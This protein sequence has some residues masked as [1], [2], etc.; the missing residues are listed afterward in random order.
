MHTVHSWNQTL[1]H[2]LLMQGEITIGTTVFNAQQ[3]GCGSRERT[4]L[5]K[6]RVATAFWKESR[7]I[8]FSVERR[9]QLTSTSHN[10]NQPW[11]CSLKVPLNITK[12]GADNNSQQLNKWPVGG[13]SHHK[14]DLKNQ[15]Q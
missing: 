5:H 14:K 7:V 10:I 6:R 3:K 11:K 15:L 13:L 4:D 1:M 8:D 2:T 9:Q 12:H